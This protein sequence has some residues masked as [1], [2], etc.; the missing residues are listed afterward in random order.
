[1]KKKTFR[2]ERAQ[3]P[4]PA[5]AK[6]NLE[7]SYQALQLLWITALQS[8]DTDWMQLFDL[9]YRMAEMERR[10]RWLREPR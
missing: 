5:Q 2:G 4:T 3:K 8:P 9:H 10:A 1:M 6:L 7:T